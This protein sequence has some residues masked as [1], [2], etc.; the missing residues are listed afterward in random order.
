[1]LLLTQCL[2]ILGEGLAWFVK[3]T[4]TN[5]QL[6]LFKRLRNQY[7]IHVIKANGGKH[8]VDFGATSKEG[9]PSCSCKGWT[10]WHIP[11]KHF[12]AVLRVKPANGHGTPFLSSTLRVPTSQLTMKLL[13]PTSQVKVTFNFLQRC[14]ILIHLK[15]TWRRQPSVT[16]ATLL[17]M[18]TLTLSPRNSEDIE[19]EIPNRNSEDIER[20]LP[21]RK[22]II[23][24][25][26]TLLRL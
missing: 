21:K 10:R 6:R 1:M 4:A 8:I 2:T 15:Q 22:V 11:C 16:L 7:F 23:I 3:Q 25:G 12:F 18:W 24:A 14:G 20:E 17:W 26:S 19:C 9:T 13:W 5:S